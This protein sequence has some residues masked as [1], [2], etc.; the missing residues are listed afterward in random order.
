MKSLEAYGSRGGFGFLL[1]FLLLAAG[2]VI[3]GW[4]YCRNYEKQFKAGIERQLS[5]IAD[6]KAGDLAQYRK[7]RLEDGSLFFQN[8][9]FAALVRRFLEKPEDAD[10]QRQLQIWLGK[11]QPYYDQVRLLDA[12][13][14][15]R[16]SSPAR[17]AGC[18]RRCGQ[19]RCG[20]PARRAG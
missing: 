5:V 2:I 17:T 10:A 15:T 7:E 16:L 6:L 18:F 1:V 9:P 14:A 11:Y 8:A 4:L 13:G 19:G 12:Q 3:T 20:C